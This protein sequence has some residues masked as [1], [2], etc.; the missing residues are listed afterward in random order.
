MHARYA[1]AFA[2]ATC[3]LLALHRSMSFELEECFCFHCSFNQYYATQDSETS[4][5]LRW[6]IFQI[7]TLS[8]FWSI[9]RNGNNLKRSILSGIQIAHNKYLRYKWIIFHSLGGSVLKLPSSFFPPVSHRKQAC[10]TL[11]MRNDATDV[12]YWDTI[13]GIVSKASGQIE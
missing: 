7:E 4:Q 12:C 13:C 3:L 2:W 10:V 6:E 11:R 1:Q 5:D 8:N 9:G